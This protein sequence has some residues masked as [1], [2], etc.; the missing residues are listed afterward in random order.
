MERKRAEEVVQELLLNEK[1][2]AVAVLL[3]LR[4]V[5]GALTQ[6]IRRVLG[7]G[8]LANASYTRS[9]LHY[10]EELGLVK[11]VIVSRHKVWQLTELGS[12]VAEELSQRLELGKTLGF[13]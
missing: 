13:S 7:K 12:A 2:N 3:Y 8:S 11:Y 5:Q 9:V 1:F 4:N 6:D 10:L